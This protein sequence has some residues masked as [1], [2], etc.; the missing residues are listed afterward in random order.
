ML[1]ILGSILVIL[2]ILAAVGVSVST[3]YHRHQ[4]RNEE[5][6]HP[7]PGKMVPVNDKQLHVFAEGEGTET[8]ILMAGHGTSNPTL[9]FAPLRRRL[10]EDYRVVVVEKTGY[11]WSD[12]SRSSRDLVT[13]LEETREA[14]KVAGEEAPYIL[15]P[16]SMSG[17]EA[18]YWAQ[19]YPE[20]VQGIIGLD[21]STPNT[22][23]LLPD[24][25]TLQ[26]YSM[27]LLSRTG[28]TRFMPEGDY[29]QN[30]PIMNT[31]ELTDEEKEEYLAVFFRSSFTMPMLRE[32]RALRDNAELV[33]GMAV[34]EDVPMLFFISNDQEGELIGWKDALTGYLSGVNQGTY[35]ELDTGHYVHYEKSDVI[36]EET[37]AFLEEVR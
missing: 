10:T 33:S 1:K 31:G 18:I 27:Y 37:R 14:L 2:L 20:E 25:P 11:G 26:L 29:T 22:V 8:I 23:E 35:I 16:H 4:L 5:I 9:D 7:P 21:P 36:V 12:S 19:K 17:L 24:P 15:M 30:F 32:T 6:V 28:L 34:P 3:A 13:M